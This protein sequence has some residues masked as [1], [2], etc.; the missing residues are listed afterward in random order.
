MHD[1]RSPSSSMLRKAAIAFAALGRIPADI[2]AHLMAVGVDVPALEE[3]L[4]MRGAV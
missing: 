1:M 2:A 4:A 3:R